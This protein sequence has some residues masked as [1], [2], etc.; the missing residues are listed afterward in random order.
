MTKKRYHGAMT[1]IER[2][3]VLLTR[4]LG[5]ELAL[6]QGEAYR[7]AGGLVGDWIGAF[8]QPGVILNA[9]T[10]VRVTLGEGQGQGVDEY[11]SST[12]DVRRDGD[13]VEL[14]KSY[15]GKGVAGQFMYV[16]RLADGVLAGYWYSPLRPAFCG[17]FWLART[18]RLAETTRTA[19]DARV[20]QRS[21]KLGLVLVLAA[22]ISCAWAISLL[23]YPRLAVALAAVVLLGRF[24][25]VERTDALRREAQLWKRDLG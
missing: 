24:V 4:R 25:L 1:A 3:R 15:A 6:A 13:R 23:G 14:R 12:F 20:R 17:V 7:E 16:G 10:P 8:A 19:L 11:G 5:V 21:I 9:A 2:T 22:V 18:D